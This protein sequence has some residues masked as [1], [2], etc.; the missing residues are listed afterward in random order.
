MSE[1]EIEGKRERERERERERDGFLHQLH[2][3]SSL[4]ICKTPDYTVSLHVAPLLNER[5]SGYNEILP[6][7]AQNETSIEEET[8]RHVDLRQHI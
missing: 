5:A 6:R 7:N 4:T 8:T 1:R 2:Q 3:L